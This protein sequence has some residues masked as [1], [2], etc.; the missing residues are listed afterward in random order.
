M[1]PFFMPEIRGTIHLLRGLLQ[2][3]VR[4]AAE[5]WKCFDRFHGI[6]FPFTDTHKKSVYLLIYAFFP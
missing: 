4:A 6:L 2:N 5:F 1:P 3:D